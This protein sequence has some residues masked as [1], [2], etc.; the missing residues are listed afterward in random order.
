MMVVDHYL[1]MKISIFKY[2]YIEMK[3]PFVQA[4]SPINVDKIEIH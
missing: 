3:S 1:A 4:K 2:P